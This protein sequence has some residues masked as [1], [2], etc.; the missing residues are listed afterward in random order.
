MVILT[1]HGCLKN[2]PHL[3]EHVK[4]L[5]SGH[6]HLKNIL[7]LISIF[8]LLNNF[9]LIFAKSVNRPGVRFEL[10]SEFVDNPNPKNGTKLSLSS[11]RYGHWNQPVGKATTVPTFS[12]ISF[13]RLQR[14]LLTTKE[15][16]R[17]DVSERTHKRKHPN[18]NFDPHFDYDDLSFAN[19]RAMPSSF[20]DA[21]Y[22]SDD[23]S[24]NLSQFDNLTLGNFS[25]NSSAEGNS[26]LLEN[27]YNTIIMGLMSV[28]LGILILVTVIGKLYM[29][30]GKT[31]YS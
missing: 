19:L 13:G 12:G 3:E 30:L 18:D 15:D 31:I 26:T 4:K 9:T 27:D 5:K 17:K 1:S 8:I 16:F 28:V 2:H 21:H 22:L 29:K 20:E 23:P 7:V 6:S 14:I 10:S 11:S 24:K 25:V